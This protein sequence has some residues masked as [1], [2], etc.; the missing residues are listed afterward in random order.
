MAF[1]YPFFFIVVTII[2]AK[3]KSDYIIIQLKILNRPFLAVKIKIRILTINF[4]LPD[5]A[6]ADICRHI[7]CHC[8]PRSFTW[9]LCS[10]CS[11]L[12]MLYSS[13]TVSFMLCL[14]GSLP[15]A[16]K[17]LNQSTFF[18]ISAHM[19]WGGFLDTNC[20]FLFTKGIIYPLFL[21]WISI[22]M[23]MCNYW[24]SPPLDYKHLD[25][26]IYIYF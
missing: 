22:L 10:P 17:S 19:L 6:L 4:N 23:G 24:K 9:F 16:T 20:M 8:F 14:E 13:Y 12:N 3:Y 7:S 18:L 1:S 25:T 26:G 5:L 21:A 2:F 15:H 11:Y